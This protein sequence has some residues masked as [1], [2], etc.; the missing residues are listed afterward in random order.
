MVSIKIFEFN[1]IQV[2]TYVLFDETQRKEADK[3]QLSE[4]RYLKAHLSLSSTNVYGDKV[5]IILWS[6]NPL[7]I[8]IKQKEI[9]DS[10][11][12]YFKPIWIPK[13]TS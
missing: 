9:A 2:N 4:I 5:A 8:L 1:P 10:Y 3:I 7:G 12:N 6:D 13:R 11:R